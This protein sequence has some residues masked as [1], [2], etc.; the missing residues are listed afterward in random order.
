MMEGGNVT[1]IHDPNTLTEALIEKEKEKETI[2]NRL[3]LLQQYENA[4]HAKRRRRH[5]LS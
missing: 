4:I 2:L 5:V 1:G 3:K